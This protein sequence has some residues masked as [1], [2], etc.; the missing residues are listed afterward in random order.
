MP[1]SPPYGLFRSGQNFDRRLLSTI[2]DS[3]T[4]PYM[5]GKRATSRVERAIM[6]LTALKPDRMGAERAH[7]LNKEQRYPFVLSQIRDQRSDQISCVLHHQLIKRQK[8]FA[9]SA[10]VPSFERDRPPGGPPLVT[11]Q[12]NAKW[13]TRPARPEGGQK[14]K[15]PIENIGTLVS[16]LKR[17]R[18][19]APLST[20][21]PGSWTEPDRTPPQNKTK[22]DP[23]GGRTINITGLSTGRLRKPRLVITATR[24]ARYRPGL[25]IG[26]GPTGSLAAAAPAVRPGDGE[27]RWCDCAR[28]GPRMRRTA[29]V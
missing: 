27:R 24:L 18:R 5:P 19:T 29:E 12:L 16:S 11:P 9:L 13:G 14:R 6:L 7:L 10:R 17:Y 15:W 26:G 28:L 2:L 20:L 23:P 25:A 3:G 22:R 1:P 21:V 4:R 8:P